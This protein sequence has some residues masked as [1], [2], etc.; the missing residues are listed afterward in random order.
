VT[1][2]R[3]ETRP[4]AELQRDTSNPRTISNAAR[5][6]L[7]ASVRRFGLVQP[8]VVNERTGRVVSGHQRLE[9]LREQGATTVDVA[10]GSWSEAE[11]RVLNVALNNAAAQGEFS[12]PEA[13]RSYLSASLRA[14]SLEDFQELRLDDLL[15]TPR[16][17][18][19][20]PRRVAKELAYKLV[21]ECQDE[22]HQAE[23]L[24]ELEQRGL[25]V[26]L[27]IV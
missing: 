2:V 16:E 18:E 6:A 20:R 27:L 5:R 11:E 26:K 15:L 14:L 25:T 10:I 21:V 23:L 3:Y 9:V 7:S 24:E 22:A 8:I 4:I 13:V 17:P 1:A 19:G 12:S